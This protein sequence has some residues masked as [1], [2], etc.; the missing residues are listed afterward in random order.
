MSIFISGIGTGRYN[1]EYTSGAAV[2]AYKQYLTTLLG[3]INSSS[4]T[5]AQYNSAVQTLQGLGDLA[6]NG[7]GGSYLTIEMLRNLA[8]VASSLQAVGINIDSPLITGTSTP[9]EI[10]TAT[11]L[12]SSWQSLGAL[13]VS[14]I[15]SGAV[16]VSASAT[17]SLQSMI[18]IDY[19]GRGNDLIAAKLSSMRDA[20]GLTTNVLN[21]LK[22]IQNIANMVT[23]Q[24]KGG[25]T[26]SYSAGTTV[27]QYVSLYK[28]AASSFFVQLVPTCTAGANEGAALFYTYRPQLDSYIVQLGQANGAASASV[29]NS[30]ANFLQNISSSI[31]NQFIGQGHDGFVAGIQAWCLDNTQ[32]NLS[33]PG[34]SGAG[35]VQNKITD[36]INA[37]QNL[38]STQQEDVRNYMFIFQQFYTSASTVLQAITQS[39]QSMA[40][41]IGPA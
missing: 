21:T 41:G 3:I 36:A 26:N 37:A 15:I 38:N 34:S 9:Q 4:P 13:G 20:I 19:V 16:G 17:R 35:A 18:E 33:Q 2:D 40:Q 22:S 29:P 31:Y 24:N 32:I 10:T 1:A 25:F 8:A 30:L 6:T 11:N 39:I 14:S 28:V 7:I 5:T 12:I 27:S 23:I